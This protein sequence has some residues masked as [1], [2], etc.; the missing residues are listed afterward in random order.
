MGITHQ[1]L[2]FA[3]EFESLEKYLFQGRNPL[4]TSNF[5]QTAPFVAV[6]SHP[7]TSGALFRI[8]TLLKHGMERKKLLE[9]ND[10]LLPF[11]ATPIRLSKW[12]ISTPMQDWNGYR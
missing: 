1:L 5:N 11:L 7:L 4:N 8:K 12:D 3:L 2:S 9:Q 6:S 10:Q